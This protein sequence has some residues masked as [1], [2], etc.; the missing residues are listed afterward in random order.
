LYAHLVRERLR[1]VSLAKVD[2]VNFLSVRQLASLGI[3]RYI[4]V[5]KVHGQKSWLVSMELKVG[6]GKQSS[7][8][9]DPGFL[10]KWCMRLR[11]ACCY[12]ESDGRVV[13]HGDVLAR[14]SR[15]GS[16]YARCIMRFVVHVLRTK[17]FLRNFTTSQAR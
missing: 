15:D 16:P 14:N 6:G 8:A 5:L 3:Q 17:L 7:Q 2:I 10:Y 9:E 13:R 12:S 4:V 1:R 11:F